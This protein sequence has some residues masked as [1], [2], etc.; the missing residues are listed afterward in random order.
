MARSLSAWNDV[1]LVDSYTG[2]IRLPALRSASDLTCFSRLTHALQPRG[3][4]STPFSLPV[5][6]GDACV[7]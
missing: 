2:Q 7:R 5:F 3:V 4:F 6:L 1:D